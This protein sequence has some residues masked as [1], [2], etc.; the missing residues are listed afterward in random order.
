MQLALIDTFVH[1][2][3]LVL[4]FGFRTRAREIRTASRH[5][6]PL[7]SCQLKD[8]LTGSKT[9][10]PHTVLLFNSSTDTSIDVETIRCQTSWLSY[11]NHPSDKTAVVEMSKRV[12]GIYQT[13]SD[14]AY[15]VWLDRESLSIVSH[16]HLM[17]MTRNYIICWPGSLRTQP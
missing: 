7:S 9:A 11:Q 10:S 8:R 6:P 5:S 12:G 13:Y 1:G 4:G 15:V 14:A 16:S 3:V 2:I 17:M